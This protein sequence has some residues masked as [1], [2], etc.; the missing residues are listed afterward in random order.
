[1][2]S[3]KRE[4]EIKSLFKELYPSIKRAITSP[5]QIESE[6]QDFWLME[7]DNKELM[8]RVAFLRDSIK[9]SKSEGLAFYDSTSKFYKKK[10]AATIKY[11]DDVYGILKDVLSEKELL[12]QLSLA[13]TLVLGG[14]YNY[15]DIAYS[16]TTAAA[17]WI[18]DNVSLQHNLLD[19]Y[20]FLPATD[21]LHNEE[22][23]PYVCHPSYG[24]EL[25]AAV[26]YLI[27][28]RNDEIVIS[29]GVHGSL[30]S[31]IN[32]EIKDSAI[33]K[34][35]ESVL[36]MID[37]E[38]IVSATRKYKEKI[39]EFYR[40]SFEIVH[41]TQ[42]KKEEL[43]KSIAELEEKIQR[44]ANLRVLS[45]DSLIS[46]LKEPDENM[47]LLQTK[48]RQLQD[49]ELKTMSVYTDLSLVNDREKTADELS[50]LLPGELVNR[51]C[52][53]SVDD[54]FEFAFALLYLLDT[55]S[56][57]PWLYYG[58]ISVAYTVCD[59]LP[60]NIAK[61]PKVNPELNKRF[62]QTL[63]ENR[64]AGNH[65]ENEEDSRGRV[66]DRKRGKNLSQIIFANSS[67]VLP[68]VS[69]ADGRIDDFI[70]EISGIEE[71]EK[72]WLQLMFSLLS[73]SENTR[74][75]L[76]LYQS[77]PDD[78]EE[79]D[80]NEAEDA[81]DAEILLRQL[82]EQKEKCKAL[83]ALLYEKNL[84]IKDLE[85]NCVQ[86]V[87]ERD[88][89]E[90]EVSDL[91]ELAYNNTNHIV[92]EKISEKIDFPYRTKNKIVSF[93]GH[94]SWLKAMRKLLPDVR[95]IEPDRIPD[96]SLIY[97]A[98]VIWIQTNCLPHSVFYKLI[99]LIRVHGKQVRYFTGSSAE[100]C[101]GQ[102]VDSEKNL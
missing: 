97:H 37:K 32:P 52:T 80:S 54:P 10:S 79:D 7:S 92:E 65:Y 2:D 23:I 16:I 18:L 56:D 100:R 55:D 58:S 6:L 74:I 62:N 36:R 49:L 1:M 67:C 5:E 84:H 9:K 40:L 30:V 72:I 39:L 45:P 98:D 22:Y 20:K 3:Y 15:V 85:S 12:E 4:N 88:M 17:I 8:E 71:S 26:T 34:N 94:A 61:K 83:Q 75:N 101:A 25:I 21:M 31:E 86:A 19:L 76:T 38:S 59:Q 46:V 87:R 68:R 99:N 42:T 44:K 73:C 33:R 90:T 70:E 81:P 63:Y 14:G 43:K 48:R 51:L 102:V 13:N 47:S 89:L 82:R 27:V 28:H 35:F 96:S 91:R 95:F 41:I 78:E 64:Y 11:F 29:N 60:F 57:L 77:L 50:D 69:V 53:F 93:G 66:V 24:L